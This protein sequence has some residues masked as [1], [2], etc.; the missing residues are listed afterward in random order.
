MGPATE[1]KDHPNRNIGEEKE[2]DIITRHS[3]TS[4]CQM[5][6]IRSMQEGNHHQHHIHLT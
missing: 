2:E 3:E 1:I 6:E 4:F 5:Y